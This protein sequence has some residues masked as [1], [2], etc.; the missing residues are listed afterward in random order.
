MA[1]TASILAQ[2]RDRIGTAT[3]F[4]DDDLNDIYTDANRGGSSVVQTAIVV[5]TRRLADLTDRSFDAA[6]AGSLVTRSQRVAY[7]ERRIKHLQTLLP[8]G[9][10]R[11]QDASYDVLSTY[12]QEETVAEF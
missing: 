4:A 7:I 12:Q 2:I 3:D 10:Y 5:W 11:G 6:T 1:L 9:D 8:D